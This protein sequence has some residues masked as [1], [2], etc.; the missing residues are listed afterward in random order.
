[1]DYFNSNKNPADEK[2]SGDF[3]GLLLLVYEILNLS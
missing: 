3:K 1:M 2:L